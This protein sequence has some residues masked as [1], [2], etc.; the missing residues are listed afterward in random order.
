MGR[1]ANDP[2]G[3]GAACQVP[4]AGVSLKQPPNLGGDLCPLWVESGHWLS[5]E[6]RG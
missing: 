1:F 6:L 4:E 5:S 2:G 3:S